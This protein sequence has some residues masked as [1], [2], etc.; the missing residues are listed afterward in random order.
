[1]GRER[2]RDLQTRT[3]ES[4][5]RVVSYLKSL[6]AQ[7]GYRYTTLVNA[8]SM[9]A[10]TDVA[11]A[12]SR[13]ADVAS[14]QPVGVVRRS[15]TSSVPF[16]GAPT[17]W[18]E[19]SATGAGVKVAVVDTGVDYTHAD[20][21]GE[22][23][24]AAYEANDPA[25]I[26]PGSFPTEKVIGGYDFVGGNYDPVDG[27]T[28]ND[29]PMPDP[30]P[31][32]D[33]VNGAHGTHVAGICCGSGVKGKVGKGVAPDA[34]ILAYK[35]WHNGSSTADV[36][37]AAYERAMDPNQ[38]GSIDDA[39]DIIQ[40]SG[41]VDY[42]THETLEAVAAQ[43]TVDLGT[44]FIAAAGNA[45][46]DLAGGSPYIGGTPGDAPGVVS[47]AAS[48]D[49][50][51][52]QRVKVMRP[53]GA[54]LPSRG[55]VVFQDW[56]KRVRGDFKSFLS[57]ARGVVKPGAK[58]GDPTPSDAQLCEKVRGRPFL[59]DL[60]LVYKASTGAGDCDGTLKALNAQRAGATGV[61][62]WSGFEGIPF[63]LSPGEGAGDVKI[64]VWMV[65]GAVGA[66]LGRLLSPKAPKR[67][68]TRQVVVKILQKLSVIPGFADRMTDFTSQGPARVTNDLKPDVSAP[69]FGIVSAAAGSGAGTLSLDGTSMAAPHVSGVAA[70]L[71][72]LHPERTPAQIKAML[73][74]TAHPDMA[75]PN[76]NSPVPA[77]IQGA[78]RVQA[79][80]AADSFSL[81]QPPSLSFG[82]QHLAVPTTL[83]P[84]TLTI[85]NFDTVT[86]T[87]FATPD[88]HFSEYSGEVVKP[89]ISA[90]GISFGP[91]ASV[92]V[93][94][95][96]TG[97]VHLR[98]VVDPTVI[99][100]AE[101]ESGLVYTFLDIDGSVGIHDDKGG[102]TESMRVPWHLVPYA[103]SANS[104]PS[105]LTVPDGGTGSLVIGTPVSAGIDQA[106][107]YQLDAADP[108][109][110][111]GEEDIMHVGVRSFVGPSIGDDAVG[112]PTGTDP[113]QELSWLDFVSNAD[114][115]EEPVEFVFRSAR[116]H[117]T[118]EAYEATVVIDVGNDGVYANDELK[119]DFMAVKDRSGTTCLVD[120]AGSPDGCARLYYPDYTNFNTNLT[121]VIV[122]AGHLGLTAGKTTIGYY[123]SLCTEAFSGDVPQP[124]CETVG[125]S[126]NSDPQFSLDVTAPQLTASTWIC[127]GF[128]GGPSCSQAI[129][130][131]K[132]EGPDV[133]LLVVFPQNPPATNVQ[134]VDIKR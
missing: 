80:K 18:E 82:L 5:Q 101:Q 25:I 9:T 54:K 65:D 103:A 21:G 123:Y 14:V 128:F 70:L 74:N 45:G 113:V 32:D 72:Q 55:L 62:F 36:L 118:T 19:H 6:G 121:G 38:D 46:N 59:G 105:E 23:T 89:G 131:G 10:T 106:D 130:I 112:L 134:V 107:L 90:D 30:D 125:R 28:N 44:V 35:V 61:L 93:P 20:F 119:G 102:T 95:G 67:Y 100:P 27:K 78:G 73:M 8:I 104:A 31:L 64:P 115:P 110:S 52:A 108:V 17:V 51:K 81:A 2:Q 56:S 47:V 58:N 92:V 63:V 42:G 79:E 66:K 99:T 77:T 11:G 126:G 71:L 1:M 41:G 37:V 26:E 57:D 116:L 29:T 60:V 122:G 88:V 98:L 50:F 34:S 120:L 87:Y 12:L 13:H 3:A 109:A 22:G 129:N 39:A 85:T 127:E 97:D 91:T 76:G 111:G 86:H 15:L 33:A 4:Q 133:D 40:F 117:N 94:P 7:V 53:R 114:T 24:R 124:I 132:T 43:E 84:K 83:G 16:I 49:Q 48:I 68:G 69:G 96:S 75:D